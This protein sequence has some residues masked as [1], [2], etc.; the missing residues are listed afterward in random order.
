MFFL[1]KYFL[2]V[3]NLMILYVPLRGLKHFMDELNYG[4][5]LGA[6]LLIPL[7]L[8]LGRDDCSLRLSSLGNRNSDIGNDNKDS[9]SFQLMY[10]TILAKK[11]KSGKEVNCAFP[12]SGKNIHLN[13]NKCICNF[14][15]IKAFY[16]NLSF[17][18]HTVDAL[19]T[20]NLPNTVLIG[21]HRLSRV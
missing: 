10:N 17:S 1:E 7:L 15:E 6:A 2:K 20:I 18:Q 9:L 4:D 14:Y 11:C 16:F 19:H 3:L 12:G 5:H 13:V 21:I 8:L